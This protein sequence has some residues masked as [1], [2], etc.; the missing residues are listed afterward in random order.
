MFATPCA[1]RIKKFVAS[2]KKVF[3]FVFSILNPCNTDFAKA[4]FTD[5]FSSIFSVIAL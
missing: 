2:T 1:S 5:F 4:C 3:L